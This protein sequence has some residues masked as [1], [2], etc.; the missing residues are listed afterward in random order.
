MNDFTFTMGPSGQFVSLQGYQQGIPQVDP[1]PIWNPGVYDHLRNNHELKEYEASTKS[2]AGLLQTEYRQVHQSDFDRYGE[3]L[4]ELTNEVVGQKAHLNLGLLRGAYRPCVI[5]EVMTRS[6]IAY[7]LVDYTQ[8]TEREAIIMPFLRGLLKKND[9]QQHEYRL[10]ITDT[11]IGGNGAEHF[12]MMLIGI[13]ESDAC[14]KAQQWTVFFNLLHD[15]E[16]HTNTGR[17][18]SIQGLATKSL[19]F[20][21]K[22]YAVPNLITEDYDGGLGLMFDGKTLKPCSEPGQFVLL[23]ETGI[24]LVESSDLRLTFDSMF[25][26]AITDGLLTSPEYKQVGDVWNRQQDK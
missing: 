23:S 18:R 14:F 8:H 4:I 15:S 10:Q 13:K 6:G 16:P 7:E 17:M 19:V 5:V 11:A 9:P 21:V 24:S 20:I 25:T 22:L 26:Q 3:V 12:A 2:L 1:Q